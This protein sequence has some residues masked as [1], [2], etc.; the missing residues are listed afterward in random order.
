MVRV[1]GAAQLL[2]HR[3]RLTVTHTPPGAPRREAKPST[4]AAPVAAAMPPRGK[5]EPARVERLY[6]R[7]RSDDV[8]TSKAFKV[9]DYVQ[10]PACLRV[11][12]YEERPRG[13]GMPTCTG[14]SS[15]LQV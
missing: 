12:K 8:T 5:H 15:P 13:P 4:I 9:T 1:T 7:G 6:R 14:P 2:G 11:E 3:W 10:C